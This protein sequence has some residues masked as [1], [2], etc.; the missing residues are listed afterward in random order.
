MRRP[1]LALLLCLAATPAL[2]QAGEH[3]I[4]RRA[5]EAGQLKPLAEI[6]AKVQA[7]HPGKVLDVDLERDRKGRRYYE[8][9]LLKNDGR[10][11][12]I[13]V[14]AETG[15]EL[16][17]QAESAAPL[18]PLAGVLRKLLAKYPGQVLDVE[19]EQGGDDHPVYE[20][21]IAQDDGRLR[22]IEIDARSGEVLSGRERRLTAMKSIKP[23]PELLD[24]VQARYRGVVHEVE[25]EHDREGRRYYEIELRLE[26]G[27]GLELHVDAVD[28]SILHEEEAD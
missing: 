2:P 23:L 4:V 28:G 19:L 18:Q 3:D 8:I 11:W 24:M 12:E 15:A 6:L 26:D 22:E 10:R 13:R 7:E 25:L 17:R 16:G 9:K 14:D 5:V 20:V 27:R 21:R 1:A